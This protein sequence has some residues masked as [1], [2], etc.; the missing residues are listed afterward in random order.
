VR[1]S[2]PR[3][4]VR[5]ALSNER[6]Y[7]EAKSSAHRWPEFS[8]RREFQILLGDEEREYHLDAG[9]LDTFIAGPLK[10]IPGTM[11]VFPG[12]KKD[13]ERKALV[14]FLGTIGD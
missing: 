14:D 10:M 7:R 8:V 11:M 6:P 2:R 13:D 12:V 1:E 5:G 3:G 9:N 4:S